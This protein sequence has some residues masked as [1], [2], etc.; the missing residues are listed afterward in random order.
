[1]A[2]DGICVAALTAE[3]NER[4]SG[5]R[6]SK[7]IQPERDALLLH[8]KTR[9]ESLK[10]LLFANPSLPLAYL[11]DKNLSGP[12]Q[13]PAFLMLI[14]KHLA[15]ARILSLHQPGLERVLCLETEHFDE[16]GDLCRHSLILE[17]MGKHSNLIL[18]DRD[19]KILDAIRRVGSGTSSVRA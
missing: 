14:R 3:L 15:G 1:M 9:E 17:I 11:T 4:L 10:L 19:A 6:I 5:G 18:C 7:I 12:A 16:L 8:I 2:F 13:A